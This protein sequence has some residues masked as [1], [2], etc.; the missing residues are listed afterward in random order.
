[1]KVPRGDWEG[2]WQDDEPPSEWVR[3]RDLSLQDRERAFATGMGLSCLTQLGGALLLFGLAGLGFVGL[4]P[5]AAVVGLV[6]I[7]AGVVGA[8]AL[9][10]ETVV[11]RVGIRPR[12]AAGIVVGAW[13]P[14][15][16]VVVVWSV[17]P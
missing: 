16:A 17:G 1:M 10:I 4:I 12:V 7:A 6:A 14:T 2:R 3:L 15:V 9:S 5:A 11:T 13:L 8:T